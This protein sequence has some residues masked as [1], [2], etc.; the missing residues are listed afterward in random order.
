M[1]TDTRPRFFMGCY[2]PKNVFVNKKGVAKN[3][4]QITVPCRKCIG[5]YLDNT[6]EWSLRCWLELK[7]CKDASFITLTYSNEFVPEDYQLKRSDVQLFL[8]RLRRKIAPLKIRFFG[9]GEYGS[10][11]LRPHY[12]LIIFG[13]QFSDLI[14]LKVTKRGEVIYRSPMLEKL[15]PFGYSSVGY[16]SLQSIRYC[17]KYLQKFAFNFDTFKVRPF[18]MC[19]TRVPIGFEALTSKEILDDKIFMNGRSYKLPRSFLRRLEKNPLFPIED[20]KQRREESSVFFE[21]YLKKDFDKQKIFS[22]NVRKR[23]DFYS[24]L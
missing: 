1:S 4:I 17:T 8:K 12:H 10:Q 11:G 22:E 6:F 16:A 18:T 20:I 23:I 5:C 2:F 21:K 24:N 3:S 13:Y 19:S 7:Q 14:K 15:W 9:C